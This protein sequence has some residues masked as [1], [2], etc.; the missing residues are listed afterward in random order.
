MLI[1][2]KEKILYTKYSN[3][4]AAS[5]RISTQ[6]VER[7]GKKIVRKS[8]MEE[9]ARPHVLA[10]KKHEIAMNEMFSGTKFKANKIL[11]SGDDF[12]D[13]EYLEGTSYDQIL[14]GYLKNKDIDGFYSAA[15]IFFD[16]LDKL[17]TVDFHANEKSNEIFGENAFVDGEKALPV[18][19]ID[20]IFQNV[21]VDSDGNWNV[22]DYEWTFDFAIP[23]KYIKY[24]SLLNFFNNQSRSRFFPSYTGYEG[25]AINQNEADNYFNIEVNGFQKWIGNARFLSISQIIRKEILNPYKVE[26]SDYIDVFYDTGKGFNG[27]EKDV[28]YQFPITVN[29]RDDLKSLR[30]DPSNHCC[31]VK[32]ISIKS[33]NTDLSFTTNAYMQKNN[34]YFFNTTDPQIYV[35]ISGH[36]KSNLFFNMKVFTLDE[37]CSATIA[38]LRTNA[39]ELQSKINALHNSKS[40]K[41]T[42]PIRILGKLLRKIYITSN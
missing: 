19:N 35:D 10:M 1:M 42:K 33:E 17:A 16:E 40:W 5:F 37:T 31:I 22:I 27:D 30:I 23:V 2:E 8:A 38:N 20:Q 15:R 39:A 4:R 7:D 6:I 28:F 36:E 41:L 34:A 11:A 18:G 26:L 32:D 14:D 9:S 12:V 24:R 29:A 3:D 13:F 21:I 25:G